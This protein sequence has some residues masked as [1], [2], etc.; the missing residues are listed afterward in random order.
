MWNPASASQAWWRRRHAPS[1]TTSLPR[2]TPRSWW[3]DHCATRARPAPRRLGPRH[4]C[5]TRPPGGPVSGLGLRE[6]LRHGRGPPRRVVSRSRPSAPSTIRR[7]PAPAPRGVRRRPRGRPRAP[8]L[9]DQR[10]GLGP[11]AGRRRERARRPFGGRED[12]ASR[13]LRAVGDPEARFREDALRMVLAVGSPRPWSST[14]SPPRWPRSPQT[15]AGRPALRGAHR[16]RARQ[17]LAAPGRPAGLRARRGN[18]PPRGD[19]ARPA[20]QQ[21]IPQNKVPART[22]G[23]TRC[24]AWMP[25]RRTARW[26]VRGVRPRHRQAVDARRG[27]FPH[28]DRSAPRSR[29]SSCGACGTPGAHRGGRPPR[30]PP[31]FTVDPDPH[32]RGRPPVHPARRPGP[33]R[34]AV[35]PPPRGRSWQRHAPRRPGHPRLPRPHRRR[36]NAEVPLDRNALA[37]DGT[38]LI[39]SWAWSRARASAT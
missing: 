23:T 16:R 27:P 3:G 34:R 19:L 33:S 10:H 30:P 1:S 38:D 29:T 24:G 4:R 8:R 31:M 28:H 32:R 26:S 35:R 9:H 22:C 5:A 2:A 37:V 14:S 18:G 20:A 13:T 39:A 15:R 36:A 12:V 11:R 25:R 6:P 21:E 17:A 7:R